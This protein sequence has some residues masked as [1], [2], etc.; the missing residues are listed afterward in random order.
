MLLLSERL[1][2]LEKA[3]EEQQELLQALLTYL[4]VEYKVTRQ[5][6]NKQHPENI[7]VGG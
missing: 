3:Y 5:I 7:T 1:E 6:V 2:I 4:N